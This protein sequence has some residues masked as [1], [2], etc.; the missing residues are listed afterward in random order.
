[1]ESTIL[2]ERIKNGEYNQKFK[3]L[4]GEAKTEAAK[5][6][7]LAALENFTALYGT[8][9]AEI[10]SGPGRSEVLGN[11]TDHNRGCVLAAAINLDIVAVVSKSGESRIRIK[12]EGFEPDDIGMEDLKARESEKFTSAAIIRGTCA[13]FAEMGYKTGGFDAYVNSGVLK[14]SGLSSSAA[15]E[16]LIG[17]ILNRLYNDGGVSPPEIAKIGQ[18]AENVYFGKPCG[19]MDQ[20]ACSVGGFV[21]IDFR[22]GEA[23]AI[24]KLD[25]EL[26][27]SGYSLCIV[28][29]GG[30]HHDLNDEYASMP[31]EMKQIAAYFGK[32]VLR[33]VDKADFDL[34]IGELRKS[35]GDRAVLRAMHY[36]AENTRVLAGAR[37]LREGNFEEFLRLIAS[38]GNSSYKY[39]QNIYNPKN[40][41]EQGISLALA[42]S[43][44][45][46]AGRQAAA[47]VHGGGFAGTIQAF[48]EKKHVGGYFKK[49][50]GVFGDDS[51]LELSVRSDGAVYL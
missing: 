51:C 10:I 38:S 40:P 16:V 36:F 34:R 5:S 1:M 48:V 24:E 22:D 25:F 18:Y 31:H 45:F 37:A 43:E 7:Y 4:Y 9:D 17:F 33:E 27:K 30:S 19:L 15:F 32:E 39:L 11:H 21:Y 14:G 50:G 6:R 23:P 35:C 46:F 20:T 42:I 41:A 28:S 26:S 13:K 2:A 44:E 47:R 8:G 29:T 12:S 49:I 3:R